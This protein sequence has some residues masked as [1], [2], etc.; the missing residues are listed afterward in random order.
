MGVETTRST[1]D[2]AVKEA[3][4]DLGLEALKPKQCDTIHSFL[5]GNDMMVVLPT[6]Y[7]KSIIY[8][9][10]F[11]KLRGSYIQ[12]DAKCEFMYFNTRDAIRKVLL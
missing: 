11:D 5:S 1:K 8:A 4:H 12:L 10:T 6:G 9:G 2:T 3:I 7:G